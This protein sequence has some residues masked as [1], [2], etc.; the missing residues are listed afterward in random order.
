MIPIATFTILAAVAVAS[1]L[2]EPP[3]APSLPGTP[4]ASREPKTAE[5]AAKC[6]VGVVGESRAGG[7]VRIAVRFEMVPGWHIY[8]QNPGESGAPT[9][10]ELELPEGCTAGPVEFPAPQVFTH[11][12]TTFGYERS[13]VLS[14]EVKLPETLPA[15]LPARVKARWLACKERCLMGTAEASVDLGTAGVRADSLAAALAESL[16]RVPQ[17]APEGW[18]FTVEGA[19]G[20]TARLVVSAPDSVAPDAE[21]TFIPFDTPGVGLASGYLSDAKGRT[22]RFDLALSRE[23]ALGGALEVGGIVI[24]GKAGKNGPSYAFRRPIPAP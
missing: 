17:P 18:K 14:A 3:G 2:A 24:L 20:D 5:E 21:W 7:R 9:R 11:G 12:E 22:A 6:T 4:P 10:I 16:A 13:V 8:W 15:S 1:A 19:T 23:S